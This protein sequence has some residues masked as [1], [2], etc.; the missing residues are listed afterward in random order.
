MEKIKFENP[1]ILLFLI[2][3]VVLIYFILKKGYLFEG[4]PLSS[5]KKE[6]NKINLAKYIKFIIFFISLF[7]LILGSSTPLYLTDKIPIEE[8]GH[9]FVFCLD[10]SSTMKALDFNPQNR[11]DKAKEIVESFIKSRNLDFFSIIIFAK[12]AIPYIPLTSDKK[13]VLEK[14]KEINTEMLEDGTA[15]GNAI[16]MGIQQIKN[17]KGESKNIIL[18]T[19]GI[20][21]EGYIHPIYAAN[22]AKK[23][24]VKIYP[25]AIG[26]SEQVPFPFKDSRGMVYTRKINIPVDYELL[27]QISEIAG[28]GQKYIAKNT[29][30]L[31]KILKMID[32][33]KPIVKSTKMY[34]KYKKLDGFFY[35]LTIIFF[36]IY[37]LFHF[38]TQEIQY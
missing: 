11:L 29:K 6:N 21:N 9:S 7:F 32:K 30:D 18:I 37:L 2:P 12:Y 23:N 25:I 33:Q 13:F 4:F 26:S 16:I 35:L 20:N 5:Y 15:I 24:N 8:K 31:Q 17:Y 34:F 19:D 22:E 28:D 14:L 3:F 38:F 1:L 10:I 36:I 27:Q